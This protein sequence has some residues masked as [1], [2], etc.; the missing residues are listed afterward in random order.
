MLCEAFRSAGGAGVG[1]GS[2]RL[3]PAARASAQPSQSMVLSPRTSSIR[4]RSGRPQRPQF[5]LR[6]SSLATAAFS[7][8]PVG[9]GSIDQGTV[10]VSTAA[11]ASHRRATRGVRRALRPGFAGR[12]S[13]LSR[14][15]SASRDARVVPRWFAMA[16]SGNPAMCSTHI[17][18]WRAVSRPARRGVLAGRGRPC[19]SARRF[20]G[21]TPDEAQ[22]PCRQAKRGLRGDLISQNGGADAV[23]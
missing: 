19:G 13:C 17:R 6:K 10:R 3:A 12:S 1:S 11:A 9:G 18:R 22:A 14:L 8:G 7:R 16:A 23:G 15:R 2:H 20:E 5:T 21:V 4:I